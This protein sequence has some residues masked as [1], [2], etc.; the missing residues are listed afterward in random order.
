MVIL[1]FMLNYMLRVNLTIA[2][3]SMVTASNSSLPGSLHA[4]ESVDECG[5][6]ATVTS[7][8]FDDTRGSPQIDVDAAANKVNEANGTTFLS[9]FPQ[10]HRVRCDLRKAELAARLTT[11]TTGGDPHASPGALIFI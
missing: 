4:N 1:G 3:V 6:R 5:A 8:P 11:S 2:I 9:T 10:R 7:S